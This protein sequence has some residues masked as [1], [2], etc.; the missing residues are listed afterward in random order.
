MK[1]LVIKTHFFD[2]KIINTF[3]V[4]VAFVS[5]ITGIVA[6]VI[7]IPNNYRWIWLLAWGLVLLIMYLLIFVYANKKRKTSFKVNGTHVNVFEGDIFTFN[8]GIKVIP[9]NEYFDV[10]VDDIII[11]K[12]SLHGKFILSHCD[13]V[14]A[15][16]KLV[17]NTLK[18]VGK[19]SCRSSS[20]TYKYDLGSIVEYNDF[21]LTAF[22]KFN[23]KNEAYLLGKEY[24]YFWGSFWENIDKM[25]SGRIIYIPLFGSGITRFKDYSPTNQ[26]L[27]E[28][29]LL[30]MRQTGFKNK[31]HDA[32]V[33][34]V[35]YKDNINDI[36]FYH[37][38]DRVGD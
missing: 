34:I 29:I 19:N 7:D 25:F 13:D 23:D 27:L 18:P 6:V 12:K 28:N 1:R 4:V 5:S 15:F 9:V 21:F 38:K 31:Y 36:D 8:N 16:E 11:S 37:L 30:T 14:S 10:Q 20:H 2:K 22:T 17:S 32:S 33:N 26:E 3:A 35:I 24:F